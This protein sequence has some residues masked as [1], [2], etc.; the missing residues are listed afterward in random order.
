MMQTDRA[1]A[2]SQPSEDGFTLW[3]YGRES[4][5]PVNLGHGP[6]DPADDE[7]LWVD[8]DVRHAE[9][10]A[11]VFQK[12]GIE[13][14][15]PDL[16]KRQSIVRHNGFLEAWVRVL[17]EGA[18]PSTLHCVVGP[19]W[20]L[21]FHEDELNLVDEF[22]KPFHG[23]TQLGD[24]NGPAFLSLVLDWQISSYFRV[25]EE[26]Q[27]DI[28]ELDGKLLTTSPDEED[29]LR[30]LHEL[31]NRVRDLRIALSPHREVFGMLS[32]PQS[33]A[34]VG[35]D[36][37]DDY[38][39]LEDRLQHAIDAVDTTREMIVGSFDIFMTRT[40]QA[41]N[42]TMK[43]LTLISVLLLPAAVIAGVMGMNF[44]VVLF[45]WPW[46]FW[47]VIGA[48]ALLAVATLV[49]AKRRGWM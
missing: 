38:Q 13:N 19:N 21:T 39:R 36:A 43:R 1:S 41:A 6:A 3:L 9:D 46:M 15:E 28:D 14:I 18:K 7:M 33:E 26:L 23:D 17:G 20:V 8:V 4:D 22:N 49:V 2:R 48:M 25:I 45:D 12:F 10:I 27:C 29:L 40:S 44:D 24:L 5:A 47:A 11:P 34:A 31:R 32:H 30:K 35:A 37:I 42:E 16:D